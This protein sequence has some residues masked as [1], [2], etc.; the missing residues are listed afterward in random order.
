MRLTGLFI[1]GAC[2]ILLSTTIQAQSGQSTLQPTIEK[3]DNFQEFI[4]N[5]KA[6]T[7][8]SDHE[9][10]IKPYDETPISLTRDAVSK[11]KLHV[12]GRGS[13][14]HVEI[15]E[16]DASD[17][18]YPIMSESFRGVNYQEVPLNRLE[19]GLYTVRVVSNHSVSETTMELKSLAAD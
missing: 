9:H 18:D 10:Y 7:E 16:L 19:D 17:E 11:A 12:K 5:R 13:L 4:N 2:F 3:I 1:L 15:Y 8:S 6:P 14:N